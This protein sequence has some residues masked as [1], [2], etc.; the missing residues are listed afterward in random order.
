M[1]INKTKCPTCPWR[2]NSPY[3]CL[4]EEL[5]LSALG[6]A[7]RICHCTGSN[8]INADTGKPEA[9]CRGA[10]DE[11]LQFFAATG[12]L[13]EATDEAWIAKCKKLKIK[14]DNN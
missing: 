6:Q 13:P 2:E 12:F 3:A 10:R 9:I 8:A 4:R 5:T 11:Q 7:S 1:K 14:P